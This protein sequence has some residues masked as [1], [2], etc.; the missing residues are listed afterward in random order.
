MTLIFKVDEKTYIYINICIY[1]YICM[2]VYIHIYVYMYIYICTYTYIY[3]TENG[4]GI[5]TR[6]YSL[7]PKLSADLNNCGFYVY[8]LHGLV[9]VG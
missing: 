8:I 3:L 1:V 6:Y 7:T 2:Y 9:K 5:C 4:S